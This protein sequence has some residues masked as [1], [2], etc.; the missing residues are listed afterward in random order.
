[1]AWIAIGAAAIS[2]YGASQQEA[3]KMEQLSSALDQ[4]QAF[5]NSGWSVSFKGDAGVSQGLPSL[6]KWMPWAVLAGGVLIAL[7]MTRK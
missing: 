7:R 2:A 1:M 3:P 5:D 6:D 4:W